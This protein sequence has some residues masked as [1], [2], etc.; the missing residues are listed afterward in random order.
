MVTTMLSRGLIR[1]E[2][3]LRFPPDRRGNKAA[4]NYRMLVSD[5]LAGA[6]PNPPSMHEHIAAARSDLMRGV[7]A[8]RLWLL[9]GMDDIRQRYQRSRVGQFWITV[10]MLVTIVALG[11]VYSYLFRMSL[12]EYL[13]SLTLGIVVWAL[14]SSMVTE[15]S[16]VFTGADSYLQQVPMPKTI[17]VYRMLVRNLVTFAHNVTIVPLL[18]LAFGIQPGWPVL[19]APIGLVIA[20]VNGFWIGLLVGM[21][22]ARFR[23]LPQMVNSLMQIAFF[24]TPVMWRQDQL[25]HEMS[26]LVDLN[27]FANLLRLIRDPFL[28][29]VPPSSAYLMGMA[30]ILAGFSVT[31][32]FF[33]RFRAR[34]IYWL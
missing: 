23:D 13:P 10:S 7:S 22:C 24:V 2:E 19:L 29:R 30:L 20:A 6:P 14:I 32:P 31:I 25:P 15:A 18:Y 26:W 1:E 34:I 28:G 11:L 27:P 12:R 33:A 8:W 5:D 16:T 4:I 21:L 17:F 9:L 3:L